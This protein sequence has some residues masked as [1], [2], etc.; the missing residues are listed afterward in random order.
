MSTVRAKWV[1][2][3]YLQSKSGGKQGEMAIYDVRDKDVFNSTEFGGQVGGY[4]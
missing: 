2:D 1:P 4:L 3:E